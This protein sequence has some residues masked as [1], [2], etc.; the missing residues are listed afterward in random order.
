M[1]KGLLGCGLWVVTGELRRD[2]SLA[3]GASACTPCTAGSYFNS[4][5]ASPHLRVRERA[6]PPAIC[7]WVCV[8]FIC[9]PPLALRES[10]R[11][12]A[13]LPVIAAE[14]CRSVAVH[15]RAR[16]CVC[17]RHVCHAANGCMHHH[18]QLQY[19][20]YVRRRTSRRFWRTLAIDSRTRLCQTCD[21]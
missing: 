21:A 10:I 1:C 13:T 16:K 3:A 8:L 18:G 19:E 11:P 14:P 7:T 20:E 2:C 12:N 9:M 15:A 17:G 5:G 6:V 4:T